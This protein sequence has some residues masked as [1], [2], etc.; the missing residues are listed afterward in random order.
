[1]S[2]END[3]VGGVAWF[4]SDSF[5]DELFGPDVMSGQRCEMFCR[6]DG[7]Y[8]GDLRPGAEHYLI[9]RT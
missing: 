9:L 5:G 1:M 6:V 8:F 3:E 2:S 4:P 7:H